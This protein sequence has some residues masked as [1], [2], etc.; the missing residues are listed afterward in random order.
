MTAGRP[1]AQ[2]FGGVTVRSSVGSSSVALMAPF[3]PFCCCR[4]PSGGAA[5]RGEG[6]AGW[7]A[8]VPGGIGTGTRAV[9][10]AC[11]AGCCPPV[12]WLSGRGTGGR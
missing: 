2:V 8:L 9:C 12:P 10:G 1:V 5:A 11:A 6:E 3:L 4:V 7:G